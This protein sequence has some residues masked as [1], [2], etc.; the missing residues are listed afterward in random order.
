MIRFTC[1]TLLVITCLGCSED[2]PEENQIY[3]PITQELDTAINIDSIVIPQDTTLIDS[4]IT[5]SWD[6]P[7]MVIEACGVLW[8]KE[9]YPDSNYSASYIDSVYQYLNSDSLISI[10]TKGVQ[11][12]ELDSV[13]CI[14]GE[15]GGSQLALATSNPECFG[16]LVGKEFLKN[17]NY[18]PIIQSL[19]SI[20]PEEHEWQRD[21]NYYG[22]AHFHTADTSITLEMR[23]QGFEQENGWPIYTSIEWKLNGTSDSEKWNSLEMSTTNFPTPMGVIQNENSK[24]ILWWQGEG[25]CC[26]SSSSTWVTQIDSTGFTDGKRW[27]GGLGQPCD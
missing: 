5:P 22:Y 23:S 25:I 17:S 8:D 19:T 6:L 14:R 13:F 3:E 10:G 15:C 12:Q 11:P 1:I 27:K 24:R 9:C 7:I 26:P 18:T 2:K 21:T 20:N 16:V 4:V